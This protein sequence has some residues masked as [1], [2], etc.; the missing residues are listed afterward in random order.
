MLRENPR[1]PPTCWPPRA[2][3]LL[4]EL[5]PALPPEQGFAARMV[6]NAMAIAAREA[7]QTP[8]G[9]QPRWRAW[10]AM[11]RALPPRSAPAAMTP[12]RRVM[13]PSRRC[14]TT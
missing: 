3:S 5:L 12:A 14:S 6:A 4:N 7:A 9:R 10:A 13:P 2:T 1:K 11:L 8:P